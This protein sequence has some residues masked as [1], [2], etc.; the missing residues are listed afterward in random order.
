M[1]GLPTSGNVRFDFALFTGFEGGWTEVAVVQSSTVNLAQISRA[2]GEGGVRFSLMVGMVRETIRHNEL[3]DLVNG[4]LRVVV[5][6]KAGIGTVLHD[7]RV[8]VCEIVL[9]LVAWTCL[10]RHRRF[11]PRPT[12]LAPGFFLSLADFGFVFSALGL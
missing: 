1:M 5:L 10:W 6:V 4:D 3:A 8:R 7:A 9:I 2:R 12:P 11:S